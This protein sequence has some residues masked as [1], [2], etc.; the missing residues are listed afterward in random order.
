MLSVA[1]IF[2]LVVVLPIDSA[3][4]DWYKQ[5]IRISSAAHSE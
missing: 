3:M 1:A 4:Y 5:A 2:S